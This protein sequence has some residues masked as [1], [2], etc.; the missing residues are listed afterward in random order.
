MA[1]PVCNRVALAVG[2]AEVLL[3]RI[4]RAI[5]AT[6]VAAGS[7]VSHAVAQDARLVERGA[8]LM[9]GIVACGSC[10]V[11]RAPGRLR[12]IGPSRTTT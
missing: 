9:N 11:A 6:S 7:I 10:H 1:G 8:Y 5:G 2:R 4:S 12:S 3:T